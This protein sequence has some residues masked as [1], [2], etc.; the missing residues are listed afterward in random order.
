M[1]KN[2]V[3]ISAASVMTA[4]VRGGGLVAQLEPQGDI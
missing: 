2:P 4:L 3:S 1:I